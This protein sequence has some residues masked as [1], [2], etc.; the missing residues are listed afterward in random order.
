MDA[1]SWLA[2][3]SAQTLRFF[4]ERLQ[5]GGLL[6]CDDYGSFLCPGARRAMDEY[7]ADRPEPI[8]ELPTQQAFVIKR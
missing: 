5:P 6:V 4:F 8:V 3:S 7:F 1:Q 2:V